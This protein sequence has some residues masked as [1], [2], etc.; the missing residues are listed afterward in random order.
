M[1]TDIRLKIGKELPK[2]RE[3]DRSISS[4]TLHV[5]NE[6]EIEVEVKFIENIS[7]HVSVRFEGRD[8][9]KIVNHRS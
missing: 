5:S 8:K 2:E 1:L 4:V 9:I 3:I 7:C 6:R